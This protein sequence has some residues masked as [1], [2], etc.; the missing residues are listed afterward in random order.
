MPKKDE[1][2]RTIRVIYQGSQGDAKGKDWG[3]KLIFALGGNHCRGRLLARP[4]GYFSNS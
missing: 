4:A 3:L 1:R 2:T